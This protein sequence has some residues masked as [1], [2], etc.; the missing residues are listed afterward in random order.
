MRNHPKSRGA[1]V[2]AL[3]ALTAVGV[4]A[5]PASAAAAA[6]TAGPLSGTFAIAPGRC[7]GA[8]SGSYF[9]MILPTG[10]P[11]GPYVSNG[12]SPCSDQTYS[13]L[14]PGSDGGLTTG[15]HQPSPS[16]AFDGAGNGVA[17]RITQP[18][19]F[20]GVRF[21]ASTEPVDP[22]TGA[23]TGAPAISVD[24]A[25]RLTGTLA[26]FGAAWNGQH[27]NQGAPKPDGSSPGNSSALTGTYDAATGAYSLTWRSQIEGGPFDNFTGVWHLEGTFRPTG[28]AASGSGV[29]T[30]GATPTTQAAVTSEGDAGQAAAPGPVA[31][32][33]TPTTVA[34]DA[35]TVDPSGDTGDAGEL[36]A[37]R[38]STEVTTSRDGWTPPRWLVLL[39]ATLGLAGAVALVVL[40]RTEPEPAP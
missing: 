14:L 34:S 16:P 29:G 39:I 37:E 19:P 38:V 32:E 5:A 33:A 8:V 21:A 23:R 3:L 13:P 18:T 10:D 4:L 27:F 25:G 30:G 11:S 6:P 26:S 20:F 17:A 28:G 24:G 9:R 40:S 22:Q 15:A 35:G 7:S 12:D 31:G 36:A 2:A 1:A